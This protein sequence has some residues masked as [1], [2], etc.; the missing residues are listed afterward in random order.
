ML[1]LE[2]RRVVELLEFRAIEIDDYAEVRHLHSLAYR[3]LTTGHHSDEQI[4]AF[5]Q[6]VRAPDYTRQ[7]LAN[8]LQGAWLDH[9]LVGTAG[10]NP[11]S[12]CGTTARITDIFVHPMFVGAGIARTLVQDAEARARSAG[13]TDFS[14]R[15]SVNAV[16]F[17]ATLGYAITSHGVRP[18]GGGID[19]PVTFMRKAAGA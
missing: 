9:I 11:A 12:D 7:L 2:E 13:F 4:A 18:L 15:A 1:G 8:D 19:V 10:W 17:F 3:I 5:T 6:F 16:P 14:A